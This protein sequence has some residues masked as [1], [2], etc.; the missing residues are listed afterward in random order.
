MNK[1]AHVHSLCN[2]FPKNR[3]GDKLISV[4]WFAILFMIA[5]AV[6]YM[7][8]I[9]YGAPKNI[10]EQESKILA[11]KV[12]ECISE[13][14]YLKERIIGNNYFKNNLLAECNLNFDVEDF[15]EWKDKPQYYLEVAIHKFDSNLPE[16]AG[17]K[18]FNFSIGDINLKTDYL[19]RHTEK[20]RVGREIDM[21]VIHVTES[22]DLDS[23]LQ[24]FAGTPK[25]IHYLI[26]RD[27]EII[28]GEIGEE[29]VAYQ[30]GN[31][32]VNQ[33]AIGI[34]LVNLG[35]KCG[36]T[37][38]YCSG[39]KSICQDANKGEEVGGVFWEKFTPEQIT[40]LE[41][42]VSGIVSRYDIP[43]D[44]EHI[45]GHSEIDPSRRTD[46]GPLFGWTDFLAN[47]K[48]EGEKTGLGRNFYVID[49]SNNQYIV[50]ILPLIGKKEKNEA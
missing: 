31:S 45:K 25:S 50:K 44:K 9:F 2:F 21:I 41:N 46:P 15:K 26:D 11:N 20:Q 37:T 34:E 12:A 23:A 40:S 47:V 10:S 17:E 48:N 36:A 30:T 42:L 7:V 32:N 22:P 14:G 18:L 1:R 39:C 3:K 4:Y 38:G 29:E 28:P 13:A 33:R 24:E 5:A 8:A 49:K 16:N 6:V 19:T 43:V 35:D 27:G